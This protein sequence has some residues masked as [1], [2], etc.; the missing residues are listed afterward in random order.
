MKEF[1]KL[2]A[3]VFLCLLAEALLIELHKRFSVPVGHGVLIERLRWILG[4]VGLAFF[5]LERLFAR[6][7]D[8]KAVPQDTTAEPSQ[9][10]DTG[11][12]GDFNSRPLF[13]ICS[14]V[15]TV[16]LAGLVIS[17]IFRAS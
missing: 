12:N 10:W 5:G 9:P 6:R 3:G 11:R 2:M 13:R 15:G 4:T 17:G 7:V 16:C 1:S 8:R 14:A